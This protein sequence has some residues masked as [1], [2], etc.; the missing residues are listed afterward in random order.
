MNPPGDVGFAFCLFVCLLVCWFVCLFVCL[1]VLG[2]FEQ[3][4]HVF[5]LFG[6]HFGVPGAP[7]EALKHPGDPPKH[8]SPA[9]HDFGPQFDALLAPFWN[10]F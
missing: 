3:G 7:G 4:F 5:L 1:Y 10:S 2:V 6:G 8:P 9:R